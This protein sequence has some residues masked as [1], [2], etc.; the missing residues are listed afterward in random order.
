MSSVFFILHLVDEEST[1]RHWKL[2]LLH[3]SSS[4]WRKLSRWEVDLWQITSSLPDT[5]IIQ[6]MDYLKNEHDCYSV[7]PLNPLIY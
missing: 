3:S 2:T 5:L 6:A 7:T 4:T 1:V